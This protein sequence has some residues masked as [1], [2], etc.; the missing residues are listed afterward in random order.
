[1]DDR[2]HGWE[3]MPIVG[4]ILF[5]S[6]I[7]T[8]CDLATSDTLT[9]PLPSNLVP[10]RSADDMLHHRNIPAIRRRLGL[11]D[12]S[13][14]HTSRFLLSQRKALIYNPLAI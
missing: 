1:M 11:S 5:Q 6:A 3:V 8:S 10:L 2:F 4:K 7:R 9:P 13:L 12:N 14:T